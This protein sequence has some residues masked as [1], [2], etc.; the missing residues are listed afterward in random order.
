MTP[1]WKKTLKLSENSNRINVVIP[2]GIYRIR[3]YRMSDDDNK[4]NRPN[5]PT[6]LS[7]FNKKERDLG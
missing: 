1:W 4:W 7:F 2:M 5:S 6:S 3:G